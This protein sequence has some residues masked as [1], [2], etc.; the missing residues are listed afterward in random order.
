MSLISI[1]TL[2]SGAQLGLWHIEESVD[3]LLNRYPS[4]SPEV[5]SYRN[6]ARKLEKLAVYSLLFMMTG[7]TTLRIT[8]NEA[9]RPF[10]N[11]WN[12]SISHTKG[13]AAVIL[14]K[15]NNV[16]I[17]IEYV[18][19][20]I[21]KIADRFVRSDEYAPTL[22]SLLLHWSAKETIYKYYSESDLLFYDMRIHDIKEKELWVDNL[23]DNTKMKVTY[24]FSPDYVL[25]FV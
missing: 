21:L 14:S 4:L 2:A 13:Y 20:R 1:E 19:P 25:T 7:D 5:S 8:H 6:D 11:G 9:G 12:I 3:E 23:K 18:S 24:R 22:E 15:Q 16:A 17:D 10:V